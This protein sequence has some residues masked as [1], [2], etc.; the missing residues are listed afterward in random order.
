M[1]SSICKTYLQTTVCEDKQ[2][3][4]VPRAKDKKLIIALKILNEQDNK[5]DLDMDL[6]KIESTPKIEVK[7]QKDRKVSFKILIGVLL[8][9]LIATVGF[10]AGLLKLDMTIQS[11]KLQNQNLRKDLK[12][13]E[14][15]AEDFKAQSNDFANKL[16]NLAETLE[17]CDTENQSLK[18]K[19]Q[20]L[21]KNVKKLEEKLSLVININHTDSLGNTKLHL[22]SKNGHVEEVKKLLELGADINAKNRRQNTSLHLAME[23][24]HSEVVKLLLQYDADIN[25]KD[26]NG[27][28][29][30]H[31]AAQNNKLEM[32]K[33]LLQNG[34]NPDVKNHDGSTPLHEAAWRGFDKI[35][36]ILLQNGA[37]VDATFDMSKY[38]ALSFAAGRGKFK[39]V[40]TL[41]KHGARK[42]L[43]NDVNRTPLQEAEYHKL[44]D[45]MKVIA[46]LKKN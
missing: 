3:S 41:L 26:K 7:L 24:G 13:Q 28:T 33:L 4:K 25:A 37:T 43:K 9:F 6:A 18:H 39:V 30:L 20:Y 2:K 27:N 40:E 38:T 29:Q 1:A 32:A 14:Q 15:I 19:N 46:L 35:A 8:M 31:F 36:E 10:V 23:N 44:G 42:D 5:S 45:Y 21:T 22:A 17:K 12:Y 34:A 11:L 16:D